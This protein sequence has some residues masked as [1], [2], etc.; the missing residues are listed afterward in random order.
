MSSL[1]DKQEESQ[2]KGQGIESQTVT[3]MRLLDG[4]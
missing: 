2:P 4:M 3:P 1:V